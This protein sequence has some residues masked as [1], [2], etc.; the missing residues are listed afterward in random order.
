[1][2]TLWGKPSASVS[3]PKLYQPNRVRTKLV[4][5]QASRGRKEAASCKKMS[6][7]CLV[8]ARNTK[9]KRPADRAGE[10]R[11]HRHA[12]RPEVLTVFKVKLHP[13]PLAVMSRPD[14]ARDT[15]DPVQDPSRAPSV[16]V[17]GAI[18]RE[19]MAEN[20]T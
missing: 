2:E 14:A 9:D 13:L 6:R 5:K 7:W 11:M 17:S 19:A 15:L 18:V 4:R 20:A 3:M 1:M 10:W 16:L 12:E 8:E